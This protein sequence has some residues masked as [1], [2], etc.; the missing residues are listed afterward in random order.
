MTHVRTAP[1][2]PQ[3]NGKLERFHKTIKGDAIRPKAPSTADEAR[4]IITAFV[5]HSNTER[6]HSAI[7][8]VTPADRLA[9]RHAAITAERDRRLDAARERRAQW[10][11]AARGAA[12]ASPPST[13][14]IDSHPCVRYAAQARVRFTLGQYSPRCTCGG[15]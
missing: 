14:S 7:D 2:Y 1:Y 13:A 9:G 5:H 10:R 11:Q 15:S 6:L 12:P 4:S 8:D 3:S